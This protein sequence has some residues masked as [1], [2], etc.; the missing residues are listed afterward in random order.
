MQFLEPKKTV[1]S[2]ADFIS[3]KSNGGLELNPSFQ[4]RSVWKS[5]SR[6]LFIDTMVRGLPVPIIF[7]R[8]LTDTKKLTTIRE[9]IDGQQRLRTVFSYVN[10]DLLDDYEEEKDGFL[11]RKSHNASIGGLVF[12]KISDEFKKRILNYQFSVQVLP[13]DTS[14]RD[15]L[16]IFRRLNSTG[17]R[18]NEQELRNAMFSGEF[19]SSTYRSGFEQL[20]RWRNWGVLTEDNIARMY[21]AELTS[22][23]YSFI[24][25]GVSGRTPKG[26]EALCSKYEDEFPKMRIVEERFSNVFDEIDKHVGRN[27]NGMIFCRRTIFYGL[28]AI[29]YD[30]MYGIGS[31]LSKSLPKKV[32]R[33]IGD[34]LVRIE[35]R[36]KGQDEKVLDEISR[37]T[38]HPS[39]RRNFVEYLQK[40]ISQSVAP[41]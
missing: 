10:S 8:E 34:R 38:T 19:I 27:L 15:V 32:E 3:W 7:L 20:E 12:S 36:L 6:S 1:F 28:F 23:L 14:D 30:L 21:E 41:A 18:L 13:S 33:N 35:S 25:N 24:L 5:T 2:V 22:D 40:Q 4:R 31:D 9:V 39:V 17:T 11:V 37:R 26:L 29:F 16:E